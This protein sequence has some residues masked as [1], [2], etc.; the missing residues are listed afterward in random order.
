MIRN[1]IV[2]V[3]FLM[4]LAACGGE[5]GAAGSGS[6]ATSAKPAASA[7][8]SAAPAATSAAPSAA[9]TADAAKPA[10]LEEIKNEKFGY[11]LML[12]KGT[13]NELADDATGGTYAAGKLAVMVTPLAKPAASPDDLLR[14]LNVEGAKVDKKTDADLFTAEVEKTPDTVNFLATRKDAKFM[15]Q[16]LGEASD[17]ELAKSICSSVKVLKK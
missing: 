10:E 8:S 14:G 11:S 12:P 5:S 17:K 15:V 7:K 13:K 1:S 2:T 16:C 9:P 6:A 4:V 3:S